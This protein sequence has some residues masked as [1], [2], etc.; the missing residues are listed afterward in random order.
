MPRKKRTI[1]EETLP[2][3][4]D[5][6]SEDVSDIICVLTKVYKL[7][8]GGKSFCFQTTEPVDEVYIQ[9]QYPTGGKF[10]VIEYNNMNTP[11]NTTH[12]D[13]EPKPLLING[14]INNSNDDM[15]TQMLM[16]ELTHSRAMMMEMIRGL[17]SK[18]QSSNTPLGEL[19][20]AM[21]VVNEIGS[22]NNPVDLIIKGMDLANKSNGNGPDW[23]A[24]LVETAKDL[25]PAVMSIRNPPQQGQYMPTITVPE[26]TIKSGIDFLKPQ[27]LRGMT[28]DLAIGWVIQNA[29]DPICN[30]L[31]GNALKGDINTF[32]SI[33]P[34]LANEPYKSWLESAIQLLKE[35][36]AAANQQQSDDTHDIERGDRDHSNVANDAPVSARKSKISKVG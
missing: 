13:I 30:Q 16:Q 4:N 25:V 29:H 34:E 27:I 15:R 35:E 21:A 26:S 1:V 14:N 9:A 33:D 12:I 7:N 3:T 8:G 31:I 22:K 2:D 19:A 28:V 5:S 10:V 6:L 17:F 18:G 24:Q 36:Y 32:I 20:Q 11:I 23:K